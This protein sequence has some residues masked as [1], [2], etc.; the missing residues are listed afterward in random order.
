MKIIAIDIDKKKAIC[1]ALEK[2]SSGTYHNLTGTKKYFEVKDD[3][4]GEEL[5]EFMKE[6]HSYFDSITPDKLGIITRQTKGRFSAS[7][8]SF[9][10]EGIIQLYDKME[11]EFIT[12]QALNAYFKKSELPL[13]FDHNYQEKAMKL[14]VFLSEK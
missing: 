3:R 6:L 2:D 9:K 14:A 11:I 4:D 13:S 12:P 1:I 10:L 5:R 8:F 7:P